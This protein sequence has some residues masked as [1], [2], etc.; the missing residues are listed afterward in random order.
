MLLWVSHLAKYINCSPIIIFSFGFCGT[1]KGYCYPWP[2][3]EGIDGSFFRR[4][5]LEDGCALNETELI[6]GDLPTVGGGGGVPLKLS[7]PE[8]C[9]RRFL[10]P[11]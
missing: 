7:T 3:P 9:F 6:G 2:P 8:E 5:W 11:P 4:K 10:K 1:G